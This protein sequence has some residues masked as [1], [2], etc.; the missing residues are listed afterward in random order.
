MN[1][2][3]ELSGR[4]SFR[5]SGMKLS[6]SNLD[7]W[8]W[9]TRGKFAKDVTLPTYGF[10][11]MQCLNIYYEFN[12]QTLEYESSNCLSDELFICKKENSHCE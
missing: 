11:N 2:F 9:M 6:D 1:F 5:T 10:N 3:S 12:L 4:C 7:R 8:I